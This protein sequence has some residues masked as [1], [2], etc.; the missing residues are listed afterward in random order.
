M[1]HSNHSLI[2]FEKG[3]RGLYIFE[4]KGEVGGGKERGERG[5]GV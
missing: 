4:K 2:R 1:C 5:R 3:A